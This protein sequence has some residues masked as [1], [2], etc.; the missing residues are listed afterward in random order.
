MTDRD[1]AEENERKVLE[2]K[3]GSLE[4]FY[5]E[6]EK[7]DRRFAEVDAT[8][9]EINQRIDT[10]IRSDREQIKA[11]ITGKY[12][13]SWKKVVWTITRCSAWRNSMQSMWRRRGI[14]SSGR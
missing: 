11:Y 3:V 8:F 4:A 1:Y 6:R 5:A 12:T 14:P 9:E 7:V 13:S 10:L 2:K